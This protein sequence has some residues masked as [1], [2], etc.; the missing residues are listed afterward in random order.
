MTHHT[1]GQLLTTDELVDYLGIP[2]G[3]IYRWRTTGVGP[4]SIRLGKHLR[5]WQKEVDAW[6]ET[7]RNPEPVGQS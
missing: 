4:P 3:T 7:R 5:F 6:I 1:N 2:K